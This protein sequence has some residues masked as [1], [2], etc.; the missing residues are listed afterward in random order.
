MAFGVRSENGVLRISTQNNVLIADPVNVPVGTG[1]F[2]ARP[3]IPLDREPLTAYL[4]PGPILEDVALTEEMCRTWLMYVS[5][6]MSN[7]TAVEGRFGLHM[8]SAVIPLNGP[9]QGLATGKL[10][11]QEGRVGPG[12]IADEILRGVGTI[13][14][15]AGRQL[16]PDDMV[17]MNMPRQEIPFQMKDARVTHGTMTFLVGGGVIVTSQGSV[18]TVDRTLDLLIEFRL[19]EEWLNRGPILAALKGEK[20]Q[21]K[22]GGTL[23]KPQVD[24]KPLLEFGKR[25]GIKAGVGA[26]FKILENRQRRRGP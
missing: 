5:P 7:A 4:G 9:G 15:V 16:N 2:R 1:R 14:Q 13:V 21:I 3:E 17:W 8:D 22:V 10:L 25:A 20:L 26:I 18:G 19:P 6:L 12:P 23:D 11:M 24:N